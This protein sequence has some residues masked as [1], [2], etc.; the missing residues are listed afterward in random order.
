MTAAARSYRVEIG[1][2]VGG[3]AGRAESLC[4]ELLPLG[5]RRGP[6]WVCGSIESPFGC[7]TSVHLSG[8]RAGIWG[9]WAAGADRESG[10]AG[11][12]LD[13]VAQV[14]FRGDKSDAVK[15]ALGWLGYDGSGGAP[16]P[17]LPSPAG[18]GGSR[19]S[20]ANANGRAAFRIWISAAAEL[21]GTPAE[22]YLRRRGID[23][24]LLGHVPGALHFHPGLWNAES[25]RKWPAL[26]AKIDKGPAA[27]AV[28]RTWL[29]DEGDK[30]PLTDPKMT[31]GSYR[32]GLV[33]L[34]KGAGGKPLKD[35]A[36]GSA[37]I[38]SEGIEDGLSCAVAA[39][40]Y[41]VAAAVSLANMGALELPPAIA[42]VIIAAQ[43]DPWWA[44]KQAKE[45][46]ALRGLDRAIR[47]F[48]QQGRSVCVARP[49]VGKDMNDLLRGIG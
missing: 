15:W 39:P 16:P 35:A 43:N 45:H 32:G 20:E 49:P 40:E 19:P 25:G 30:A 10:S 17:P 38:L 1:A 34:W 44:E 29:T 37:I 9:A 14:L 6:E 33:P 41:R 42:C 8:A 31:L 7:A 3:L 26:V 2:I 13:L 4:R 28:H 47:H 24:E 48:Q 21:R 18:G 46:G 11:D 27:V 36:P 23:I 5:V 12:A 22:I